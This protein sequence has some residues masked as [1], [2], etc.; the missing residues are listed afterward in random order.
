LLCAYPPE[1]GANVAHSC[2]TGEIDITWTSAV[3][4]V[5]FYLD[6]PFYGTSYVT[7]D[8]HGSS[9]SRGNSTDGSPDI[10]ENIP[11][12]GSVQLM[13]LGTADYYVI[14][15]VRYSPTP[16]PRR[17]VMHGSGA[18]ALAGAFRR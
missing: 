6:N 17:F 7:Y 10:T 5:S 16:E 1:S 15:D 14:D 2:C 18:L 8:I 4:G 9:G 12:S 11:G 13:I 3:L